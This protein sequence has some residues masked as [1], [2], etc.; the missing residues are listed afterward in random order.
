MFGLIGTPS[1]EKVICFFQFLMSGLEVH[2]NSM[3]G[4]YISLLTKA[5]VPH[6][7][8]EVH[9]GRSTAALE[10][11][12]PKARRILRK[13]HK[14]AS[15]LTTVERDLSKQSRLVNKLRYRSDVVLQTSQLHIIYDSL[16]I[17]CL[18]LLVK[19]HDYITQYGTCSFMISQNSIEM[20]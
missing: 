5:F 8:D 20:Y 2:T 17:A 16:L 10:R 15:T 19:L 13:G 6:R 18:I 4:R 7:G 14:S 12:R 1:Q 11:E 3:L 9:G